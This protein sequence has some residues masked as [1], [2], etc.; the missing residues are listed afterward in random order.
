MSQGW[1]PDAAVDFK[2]ARWLHTTGLF[3]RATPTELRRRTRG[4]LWKSWIEAGCLVP[5]GCSST[6]GFAVCHRLRKLLAAANAP[7]PT[8]MLKRAAA[9]LNTARATRQNVRRLL[10]QI[11]TA[12]I[13]AI[14]QEQ[15]LTPQKAIRAR[16]SGTL[17]ELICVLPA[18][19]TAHLL[20]VFQKAAAR[21]TPIQELHIG[22]V[23]NLRMELQRSAALV[24]L[25]CSWKGKSPATFQSYL[26]A[27]EKVDDLLLSMPRMR[28]LKL[29][30][31][32]NSHTGSFEPKTLVNLRTFLV[33][34]GSTRRF[35][36]E[37]FGGLAASLLS[38]LCDPALFDEIMEAAREVIADRD[39]ERGLAREEQVLFDLH[40]SDRMDRLVEQRQ[41]FVELAFTRYVELLKQADGGIPAGGLSLL[42]RTPVFDADGNPVDAAEQ[43]VRFRVDTPGNVARR[44]AARNRPGPMRYSMAAEITRLEAI[45]PSPH[46]KL[47][48]DLMVIYDGVEPVEPGGPTVEPFFIDLYR[49]GVLEGDTHHPPVVQACREQLLDEA[50]IKRQWQAIPGLLCLPR[51]LRWVARA[52]R[53]A[54]PRVGEVVVPLVALHHGLLLGAACHSVVRDACPRTFEILQI[55]L[56]PQFIGE[57]LPGKKDRYP[58][59]MRPKQH[60]VQRSYLVK[61]A[62]LKLI[63]RSVNL[64]NRRWNPELL[65]KSHRL[66]V[67]PAGL[68]GSKPL[69]DGQYVFTSATRTLN[70]YELASLRHFILWNVTNSKIHDGRFKLATKF[71]F[72]GAAEP[73]KTKLLKQRRG[74]KQSRRYDRSDRL[75][76]TAGACDHANFERRP[77]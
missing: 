41:A 46:S 50:E 4:E 53:G 38:C 71:G 60:Q 56:G 34:I 47:R 63:A 52:A 36:I 74:S 18:A 35:V 29:L 12:E 2:S 6:E 31:H 15:G 64:A 40:N 8:V 23:L 75:R 5:E 26:N 17:D 39:E 16:R 77:E 24:L 59:M 44:A 66:P 25:D 72:A 33:A 43:I 67:R 1:A 3:G 45:H 37:H 13:A 22:R 32:I 10:G 62:T 27:I 7:H 28:L 21:G 70:K 55:Q 42:V 65:G 68:R 69:P 20:S 57:E 48:E 54:D 76:A 9:E 19:Q 11:T 14:Q 58:I 73:L 61:G 51:S 49:W 30:T